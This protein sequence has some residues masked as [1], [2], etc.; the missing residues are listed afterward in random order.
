MKTKQFRNK[1]LVGAGVLTAFAA[2]L[3][4]ITP[5]LA[6]LGGISGV[7]ATFSWMEPFRPCFISLTI[8]LLAYVWYQKLKQR[9]PIDCDCETNPKPNFMQTKTFL[10]LITAFTLLMLTFPN[11]AKMFYAA[12]KKLVVPSILQDNTKT[13]T[14]EFKIT[15]MTCE[16]CTL[17]V[18]KEVNKVAGIL[19]LQVSYVNANAL[20]KFDK[21]KTTL[22]EVQKAIKLTGYKLTETKIKQ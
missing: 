5:V 1:Q 22:Q 11:Y 17:H 8:A 10:G 21:S 19:D 6:L 18:A 16:A 7:A 14:A 9:A 4:C 3:C 2:S 12:P 15:G 13:Q 20:V